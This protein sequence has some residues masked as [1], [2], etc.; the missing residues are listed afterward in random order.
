MSDKRILITGGEG[1]VGSYCDFGTRLS[2]TECD[3]TN[4]ASVRAAFQKHTPH[5][6]VHCAAATDLARC[7]ADPVYAYA[8]NATGTYHVAL[9]AREVGAKLIYLSTSGVFDGTKAE[10]YEPAD[11]PNPINV[12]GHSKYLGELAAAGVLNNCLI[13]RT[14]WVF[15]GGKEKDT[16]FVGKMLAQ[17]GA[18]EVKAV[19]DHRGSPTYA[20]DLAVALKALVGQDILG[21]VHVGGGVATREELA[22]EALTLVRSNATVVPV[23]MADFTSVYTSGENE[24]MPASPLVRSWRDAL[25]EYIETEW[26]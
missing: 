3:V 4:L 22:K 19:S 25:R 7:E 18:K 24:S 12:Y 9:A 6:V 15:G 13:V 5:T 8:V 16:K 14:S 23:P 26:V 2:R 21:I 11:K 1:V 20:K 10:P 17:A